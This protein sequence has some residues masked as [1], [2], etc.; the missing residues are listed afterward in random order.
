[1]KKLTT[2]VMMT[3]R[4]Q[5]NSWIL[6]TQS[7]VQSVRFHKD[8]YSSFN[9]LPYILNDLKRICVHGNSPLTVDATFKVADNIWLTTS[10]YENQSLVNCNGKHPQFP[11]PSQWQFHHNENSFI[12][13]AGKM[14][15]ECP[16][17][18]G[19]KRIGHDWDSATANGLNRIFVNATQLCT[20]HLQDADTRKL[21][22]LGANHDTTDRIMAD[23]CGSQVKTLETQG[24][25]DAE[26][27]HDLK[28]KLDS[29]QGIWAD[30]VPGFYNFFLHYCLKLFESCLVLSARERLG[31]KGRF[32]TN[33]L[34]LLNHLLTKKLNDLSCSGD[35]RDVSEGLTKWVSENFLDE[36]RKA[37]I[38]QG[39]YRLAA[40]YQQFAVDPVQ[41]L[42]WSQDCRSQHVQA[43]LAFTA[44]GSS[45]YIKPSDA[46]AKRNPGEK[47]GLTYQRLTSCYQWQIINMQRKQH[48]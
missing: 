19:I 15:I 34:E 9:D 10:S 40:G 18:I 46:G 4:S 21:K 38:G 36:T 2:K 13:F 44:L 30:L 47:E 25:A 37:I 23:I 45:R 41:W 33:G 7:F 31:I 3:K 24:L 48:Q 1:M 35:I 22:V 5:R 28:I 29:L 17:L 27:S 16:E 39:K 20:R 26:D 43:F 6:F 8:A 14:I 12:H 32:Y 42:R 11:S